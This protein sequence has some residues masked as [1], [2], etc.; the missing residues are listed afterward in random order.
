MVGCQVES[1]ADPRSL[2]SRRHFPIS[3]E[4]CAGTAACRGGG[5]MR[6]GSGR[7]AVAGRHCACGMLLGLQRSSNMF[8]ITNIFIT[9]ST[10][11]GSCSEGFVLMTFSLH[12]M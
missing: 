11:C 12:S 1:V 6:K 8:M 5:A 2:T 9:I 7:F 3:S 4:V 10:Y